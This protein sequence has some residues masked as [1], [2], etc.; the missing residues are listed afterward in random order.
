MVL[1]VGRRENAKGYWALWMILNI[2]FRRMTMDI[3]LCG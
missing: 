1:N 2:E 3:G